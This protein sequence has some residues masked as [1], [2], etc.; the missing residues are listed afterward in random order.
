MRAEGSETEGVSDKEVCAE[1]PS[2][3]ADHGQD[4]EV[5]IDDTSGL[6]SKSSGDADGQDRESSSLVASREDGR[7]PA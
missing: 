6:A 5:V 7:Q 2:G 3:S 4:G 1:E